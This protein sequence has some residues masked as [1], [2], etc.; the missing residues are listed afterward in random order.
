MTKETCYI[1]IFYVYV[2]L[3]LCPVVYRML[4]DRD[5]EKKT[6]PR[7]NGLD[8]KLAMCIMWSSLASV[9][10]QYFSKT[11]SLDFEDQFFVKL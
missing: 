2:S 8:T 5:L 11:V 10:Y 3:F 7:N 9:Q 1:I 4:V 6:V